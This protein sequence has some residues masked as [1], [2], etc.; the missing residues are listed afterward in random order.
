MQE[1]DKYL[2]TDNSCW[3]GQLKETLSGVWMDE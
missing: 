3:P 1:I 2:V